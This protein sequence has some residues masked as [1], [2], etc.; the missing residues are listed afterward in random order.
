MSIRE[1]YGRTAAAL[2]NID[3]ATQLAGQRLQQLE[4][5]KLVLDQKKEVW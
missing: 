4:H 2:E 3:K 5:E 1:E